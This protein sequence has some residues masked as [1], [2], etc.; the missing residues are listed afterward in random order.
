MERFYSGI[1]R[2][3]KVVLAA[4]LVMA[5]LCFFLEKL[6]VVNYD[7]NDY[8]PEDS[9]STVSLEVMQQEFSGGIPNTREMIHNV[10]IP[11]ALEYKQ[12]L[13]EVEG[14]TAV[15]WLDDSVDITVPL[16]A[17][18]SDVVESHYKDGTA[19]F[20]VTIDEEYCI[21]AI[22][23]IREIVGNDNAIS[24]SAA[25]IAVSTTKTVAEVPMISAIAVIF[26]LL[27]LL[28]TTSAWL[29]P[30]VVLVG[31]GVAVVINGGTHLIFGEISFI[32]NAAGS[33]LQLAVSLD[34]SVFL[35]HRFSECLKTNPDPER[36]MVDALCKSTSS[37]LSS[38][39]TT[40]IGFLALTLMQFKIGP[41]LGL[42]LAK[43]VAISLITVFMFTPSLILVAHPFIMR[44]RHRSFLPDFKGFG[45]MVRRVAIPFVCIFCIVVLPAFLASNANSYYY[46]ASEIFGSDTQYGA[47][48][49]ATDALFGVS[50]TYVL[51]VPKG[52]T[53]M[54]TKLSNR[55]HQLDHVTGIISF[56]DMAGAEI[57]TAYLDA[58]TLAL[59]ESENYAR[60]VISVNVPTEG[61]GTFALVEEIR[62]VAQSYYP[63]SYYLAGRGV[64]TYDLMDAITADML[65]VNLLAIGAV[66][67]ILL[68]TMR[69]VILPIILVLG[70]ETAIWLNLSIPY[71]TDS[72]IFY[73]AYLIISAIQLGATVD[74][75][76][77]MADRY[78]EN[79]QQL[80]RNAAIIQTISDVT[81]SI[82]ISGS[83]MTVV[84][85]LMSYLSS[86]RLLGQLGLLIGRG[87]I[88]SLIIVF[89]VLPGLLYL[90]DKLTV[91]RKLAKNSI[92]TGGF[93][94]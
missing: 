94:Q 35:L 54:Q 46:G 7:I 86:N 18:D 69:S 85:M 12:L 79:R 31:I 80:E 70:I 19:L 25:S 65:K 3:R 90:T 82:L 44:T 78:R 8:L 37:I 17:L 51:M 2:R 62:D 29:S 4:F 48:T 74:Y 45:K 33:I 49:E 26:A 64:S 40:V 16:A 39:L 42:A 11:Q 28:L 1:V 71:F 66:F 24:G 92:S 59:L 73:I 81:V 76:I 67:L 56:V 43:G 38:G 10:T 13:R 84:G 68:L 61:E 23:A 34:Y 63:D 36:A 72:P 55:L 89:F 53:A 47:D 30:L 5:A 6:V 41:D 88:F 50:D 52:N 14:V 87:A 58:A 77:L 22:D 93:A 20:S 60:M 27:V 83:V 32:T 57:P 15:T 21:S 91:G 9:H 75:A